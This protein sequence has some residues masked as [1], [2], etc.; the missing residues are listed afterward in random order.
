[1]YKLITDLLCPSSGFRCKSLNTREGFRKFSA[2]TNDKNLDLYVKTLN[3][4][5]GQLWP[6]NHQF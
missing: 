4:N 3:W 2:K 6:K 5:F 1:M